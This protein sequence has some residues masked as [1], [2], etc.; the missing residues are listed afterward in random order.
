[1]KKNLFYQ[2]VTMFVCLLFF[3]PTKAADTPIQ[4]LCK[5]N[6][7]YAQAKNFSMKINMDFFAGANDITPIQNHQ[8]EV[9]KRGDAYYSSIM[10]KIT[11]SNLKRT[12]F[13]DNGQQLIIY[14][15]HP[16]A[17]KMKPGID[18]PDTAEFGKSA[19]YTYGQGTATAARI[20][21]VPKDQSVYTRIEVLINRINNTLEE[22]VYQYVDSEEIAS[23]VQRIRI[24]YSAITIN[25]PVSDAYFSEA[26]FI[27]K[28]N[29]QWTG[30]GRYLTYKV[31]EQENKVPQNL[32][33]HD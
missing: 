30:V 5:M 12:I 6:E 15:T 8:G 3:A 32:Q 19:S 18:L 2:L 25:K 23:T 13:V 17:K 31:V 7:A 22:V 27:T 10:G 14:S 9:V 28:K 24:R 29:G 26:Q 33:R 1:M 21:I 11:L 4:L 16:D 20:V